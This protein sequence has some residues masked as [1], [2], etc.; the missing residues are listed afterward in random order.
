MK[1]GFLLITLLVSLLVAAACSPASPK[2][3]LPEGYTQASPVIPQMGEHWANLAEFQAQAQAQ[4]PMGPIYNVY[5]G[6]VIGV[7]YMYSEDMLQ[8]ISI[9]TPAGPEEFGALAPLPVGATV[10]HFDITFVP[11]GHPGIYEVPHWDIH[12]YFITQEEKVGITP[13]G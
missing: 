13:G 1:K 10:D 2:I 5:K 7:E 12:L 4:K 11:H 8:A 9:P 6:E 3:E